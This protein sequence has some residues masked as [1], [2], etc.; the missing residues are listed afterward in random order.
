MIGKLNDSLWL[1]IWLLVVLYNKWSVRF[2][3][4]AVVQLDVKYFVLSGIY[5]QWK[6]TWLNSIE[7]LPT[8]KRSTTS[9][10]NLFQKNWGSIGRNS[11]RPKQSKLNWN[12]LD[13]TILNRLPMRCVFC[14]QR[15]ST[16]NRTSHSEA[17]EWELE[18]KVKKC[19]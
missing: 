2:F 8:N 4:V 14:V 3:A 11:N 1:L 9:N 15:Q 7:P 16:R 18:T 17:F 12:K 5:Y 6:Q 10:P 19:I 13:Q